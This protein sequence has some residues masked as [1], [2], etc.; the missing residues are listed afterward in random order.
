MERVSPRHIA[1]TPP[2]TL[3]LEIAATG[4]TRITWLFRGPAGEDIL[5]LDPSRL[6][7]EDNS[8]RVMLSGTVTADR[9]VYEAD[10]H[11]INGDVITLKCEACNRKVEGWARDVAGSS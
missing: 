8:K 4:Y 10:V 2:E 9:G 1:L 7:L 3:I 11:T 6:D 5:P